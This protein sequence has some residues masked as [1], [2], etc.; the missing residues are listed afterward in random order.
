MAGLFV[1][2]SNINIPY[3]TVQSELILAMVNIIFNPLTRGFWTLEL[4]PK[5]DPAKG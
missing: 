1:V 3:L 5:L 4:Y 2:F